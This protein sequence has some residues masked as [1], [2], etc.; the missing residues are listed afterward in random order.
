MSG[1]SPAHGR[2]YAR[3]GAVAVAGAG[4]DDCGVGD[5]DDVG[6]GAL[7]DRPPFLVASTESDYDETSRKFFQAEDELWACKSRSRSRS[8]SHSPGPERTVRFG[9]RV[10]ERA[11]A[12]KRASSAKNEVSRGVLSEQT[13]EASQKNPYLRSLLHDAVEGGGARIVG[14]ALEA[15]DQTRALLGRSSDLG[16][17]PQ[18]PEETQSRRTQFIHSEL[19]QT[20]DRKMKLRGLQKELRKIT[21]KKR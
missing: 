17:W 14:E 16:A 1:T 11:A 3:R 4:A 10:E 20:A 2:A 19:G 7:E 6:P 9:E 5:N 21:A 18:P 13:V 8:R 12:R 15:L